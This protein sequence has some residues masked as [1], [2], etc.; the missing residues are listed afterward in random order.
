MKNIY[1][2]LS[3]TPTLIGKAVRIFTKS[4]FN[5][6]SISLSENWSEMYSF[7]RYRASNPLVGGFVREFPE[8]LSLGKDKSV[9][10]EVYK[11]PVS[12]RQFNEIKSFIY[13]IR[14][15]EEENIYNSRVIF[16]ILFK[17]KVKTYKAYTCSEFV[18][19]SLLIG[20][21]VPESQVSNNIIPDDI[22]KIINKYA[23]F[24]GCLNNYSPISGISF[25]TEDFFQ[26]TS[27]INETVRTFHHF[28]RLLQRRN[29]SSYLNISRI[30][31][32]I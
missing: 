29:M 23:F 2:I 27:V 4:S 17:Q 18:A 30:N 8:R 1:V 20:N 12:E 6:S 25:D 13:S 11:I 14:D 24:S 31:K 16:S 19:R 9:Y 21:L 32:N 28:Y 22:Q 3:V 10:I 5:H 7:A 15:D 26:K